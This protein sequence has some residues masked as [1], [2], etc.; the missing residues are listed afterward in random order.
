MKRCLEKVAEKN[1][2]AWKLGDD[3]DRWST[4]QAKRIRAAARDISQGV[5]KVRSGH[6]APNW[7][8][9]FLPSDL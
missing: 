3:V 9:P 8:I 6:P 2:E 7:L 4:H 5:I 1:A